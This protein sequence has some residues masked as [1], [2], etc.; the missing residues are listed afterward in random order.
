MGDHL[1]GASLPRVH[2]PR[3]VVHAAAAALLAVGLAGCTWAS[4]A[5]P[6]T[7]SSPAI[8][9]TSPSPS[10]TAEPT[11]SPEPAETEPEP[12]PEPEPTQSED[13]S[14]LLIQ[15]EE[16]SKT[17]RAGAIAAAK[18]YM[19]LFEYVFLSG[20]LEMW[21]TMAAPECQFCAVV[22]K[23]AKAMHAEGRHRVSGPP[24]WLDD[25]KTERV[26]S[27]NRW[28]VTLRADVSASTTFDANGTVVDESPSVR[29]KVVLVMQHDGDS[30][31]TAGIEISSD[32]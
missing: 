1:Q 19:G 24:Q 22:S 7:A 32:S 18:Y 9:D 14:E 28:H 12:E 10:P 25:A 3:A 11:P 15:P 6:T 16:M 2:A 8:A 29:N 30:W 23:N 17:G 13:R 27:M 20:D 4:S 5:P 26:V 31:Q 21:E